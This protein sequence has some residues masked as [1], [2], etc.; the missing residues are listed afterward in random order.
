MAYSL[1]AH[2]ASAASVPTAAHAS[3]AHV[4]TAAHA[5][6]AHA[7]AAHW[8]AAAACTSHGAA[9]GAV[10]RVRFVQREC[11]RNRYRHSCKTDHISVALRK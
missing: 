6:A 11:V 3:A 5:S 4:P 2:V 1:A 7:S 10:R 8:S 9:Q